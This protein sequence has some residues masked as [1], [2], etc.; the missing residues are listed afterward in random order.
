MVSTISGTGAIISRPIYRLLV[1]TYADRDLHFSF[2]GCPELGAWASLIGVWL[3]P[4]RLTTLQPVNWQ[5]VPSSSPSETFPTPG[6]GLSSLE[7]RKVCAKAV[8]LASV[9]VSH[10]ISLRRVGTAAS[11]FLPIAVAVL[12]ISRSWLGLPRILGFLPATRGDPAPNR[13]L[14]PLAIRLRVTYSVLLR[15]GGGFWSG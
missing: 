4:S 9:A 12:V 3:I 11:K 13:Y 15:D 6:A 5:T 7:T 10:H 2:W 8:V 1:Y 14:F